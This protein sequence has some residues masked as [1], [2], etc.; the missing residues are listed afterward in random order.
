MKNV[1]KKLKEE[2]KAS[3]SRLTSGGRNW[4][5]SCGTMPMRLSRD[6]TRLDSFR[7]RLIRF[8]TSCGA[9]LGFAPCARQSG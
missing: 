8:T 1:L 4:L 9:I 5:R 2:L 3:R 7:R 6:S